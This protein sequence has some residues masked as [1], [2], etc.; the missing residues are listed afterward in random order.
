MATE[1]IKELPKSWAMVGGDGPQSYTQNSSYQKGVV[2][3]SKEKVTEG[4]KDKLDFKSLGFDSSNDTFRIADFGCSVGP[5]T[6]FAVENIIEAVEQKYQCPF[7]VFFNDVTTNDFNTLFKTLHSNRKYFAAG[8]P[9][10]FY[11]RLLP[12]STLHLAYSS[13][14][15]QWLS[16]V[17][18][19]VVD[20]KSPAWNK[21]SIQCDGLKKEVTKAYSAQFQSDMNTFLNAR[22][23]EIVGGGLMVIIMAGLPD[24]IFMSQAGVGMYYDLLGSCLVDMAKLGE[25]SEE[26]LDSFN[27]PLYYSSSTEIEEIIKVN[28]NFSIEIMDLLSH[29]IWQTSKK[30]NIDISVS[31]GRAVFQGLVEEHFGSEV[32]EKTFEHFAKKLVDNFSI[33]DG[34]AHEHIDHFILLKR[35]FN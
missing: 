22:A 17:P 29:Q 4:I 13:Y 7:Q 11:G 24:G 19:E 8:L 25:I 1:E 28:G 10:T 26:K 35:H 2:D 33:F 18:N 21:G 34:A 16:K 5:N 27:L 9:G 12:K 30:S 6:F 32:V 14:C 20:S 23:Q 31:G 15:L 3:A